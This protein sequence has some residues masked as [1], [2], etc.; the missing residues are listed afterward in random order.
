MSLRRHNPK[1]DANEP[2]IV[3][4]LEQCGFAVEPISQRGVPDLL[5]SRRGHWW[6]VETKRPPGPR[7]GLKGRTLTDEQVAFRDRHRAPVQVIR[8]ATEAVQW[9]GSV[10]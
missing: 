7:G 8:T 5:V 6:T 4:A 1:R 2:E 9:A 10:P 3:R